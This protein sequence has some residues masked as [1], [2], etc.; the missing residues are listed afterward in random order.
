MHVIMDKLYACLTELDQLIRRQRGAIATIDALDNM[1]RL[2]RAREHVRQAQILVARIEA[3]AL[4]PETSAPQAS[5][6]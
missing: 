2:E 4:P 1:R 5:S 6:P 3:D